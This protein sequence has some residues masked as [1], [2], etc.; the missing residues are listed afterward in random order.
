MRRYDCG[1]S[2]IG[3]GLGLA[4]VAAGFPIASYEAAAMYA[5]FGVL[6]WIFNL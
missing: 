2:F 1:S 4:L 3:T 6:F 5:L